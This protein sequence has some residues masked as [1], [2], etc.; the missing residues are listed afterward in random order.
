MNDGPTAYFNTDARE[1]L[2]DIYPKRCTVP[3]GPFPWPARTSDPNTLRLF[4]PE[5]ISDILLNGPPAGRQ[6]PDRIRHRTTNT[7]A[8]A[9]VSRESR[10]RLCNEVRGRHFKQ[11]LQLLMMKCHIIVTMLCQCYL[12]TI[13]ISSNYV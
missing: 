7:R 3:G 1:Y 12:C 10:C 2:H 13:K 9:G 11:L 6:D 8:C 5:D 4:R